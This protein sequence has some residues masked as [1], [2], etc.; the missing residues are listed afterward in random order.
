MHLLD[1]NATGT[2]SAIDGVSTDARALVHEFGYSVVRAFDEAGIRNPKIIRNLI[3]A[4]WIGAREPG[5][6]P[7]AASP[8]V[9]RALNAAW[10]HLQNA[11][12]MHGFLCGVLKYTVAP[13]LPSRAMINAS[14]AEMGRHAV[15][16]KEQKHRLRLQAAL[17]AQAEYLTNW[18]RCERARSDD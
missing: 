15:V 13:I 5:N 17:R 18:R 11:E 14:M 9:F 4:V 7:A 3:Y 10:P 1:H 6:K 2:C 16:S 12:G 8:Q